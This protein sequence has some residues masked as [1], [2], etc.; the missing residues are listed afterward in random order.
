MDTI[1]LKLN[2]KYL[3]TIR[4]AASYFNIGEK[5]MRR[6]AENNEGGFTIYHGNRY[7]IVRQKFEE[8]LLE[9]AERKVEENEESCT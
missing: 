6:I 7:L 9:K 5:N 1:I 2:E 8:Y 4:E 3:L